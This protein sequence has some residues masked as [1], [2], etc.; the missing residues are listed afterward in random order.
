MR[1]FK[2][3]LKILRNTNQEVRFHDFI[4]RVYI[5]KVGSFVL[6]VLIARR[7]HIWA[8]DYLHV[9]SAYLTHYKREDKVMF[10]LRI[11][12]FT[13][14]TMEEFKQTE[15]LHIVVE[16]KVIKAK[17]AQVSRVTA[18]N[19]PFI[20][21]TLLISNEIEESAGILLV[22]FRTY[23]LRIHKLPQGS[24]IVL[25]ARMYP[26]RYEGG[27]ELNITNILNAEEMNRKREE[28]KQHGTKRPI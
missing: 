19:L 9:E 1:A 14:I 23:A 10:A 25:S 17:D 4:Y 11:R 24:N 18:H 5:A 6:P 13:R 7:D 27:F 26:K 21:S 12:S 3:D 2:V 20:A 15:Y 22:A 16:G 8:G 28:G